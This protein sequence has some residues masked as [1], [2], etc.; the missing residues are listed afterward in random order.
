MNG[1]CFMTDEELIVIDIFCG[2]GGSS[3]GFKKAGFKII[4]GLDNDPWACET[5]ARNFG[6]Q[7]IMKDAFDEETNGPL[8]LDH[9]G[10]DPGDITVLIGCPPCQ[11]FS[12]M[13]NGEGSQDAR[14]NLILKFAD[15]VYEI[16]PLFV[17]FENVAGL[18]R[19]HRG[20]F[21]VFCSR[22]K[23]YG[24]KYMVYD[25]LNAA[26]YGVPQRRKRLILIA[27]Y[28]RRFRHNLSLPS[29]SHCAPSLSRKKNLK[30]WVTVREFISD[31][32]PLEPGE[33][34]P[35]I[36]NHACRGLTE[37][38]HNLIRMIPKD[39]GTIRDLPERYW[40]KCHKKHNGHKDVYG[41][42][43]WDKVAPTLT[44]GC[45]NPSKGRFIH[46]EQDRGISLREAARLQSF[47]D[48]FIFFGPYCRVEKQIG[49]AFP[50]LMAERIACRLRAIYDGDR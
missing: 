1:D 13:R 5:F 40:L 15:L 35:H 25:V 31:L 28:D 12:R 10:L 11:G 38:I 27:T 24:Y 20:Y 23:K 34:H 45:T 7:P 41:R 48:D 26:D 22:L 39:G 49:N 17:L 3:L 42:M 30:P 36:P 14:N 18:I 9:Y 8:I 2:C 47:P 37:R 43:W 32:P 6:V 4:G 33:R 46:P 19:L 50:P 29:P 21:D 44:T 16:K